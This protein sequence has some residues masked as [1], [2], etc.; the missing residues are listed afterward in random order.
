[1]T[2]VQ[3]HRDPAK[4]VR[5]SHAP[6]NFVPLSDRVYLPKASNG[7]AKG[8]SG[9]IEYKILV[10]TPLF[11]GKRP[12]D[13]D[14]FKRGDEY[15]IPGGAVRGMLRFV[16]RVISF[17]RFTPFED[18][19]LVFR[20][21]DPGTPE[22]RAYNELIKK[23]DIHAGFLRKQG[24]SF[25][26]QKAS[27]VK[28]H[29]FVKVAYA[30]VKHYF[31][32]RKPDEP[33]GPSDRMWVCLKPRVDRDWLVVDRVQ[34][35]IGIKG[36]SKCKG[37]SV[38]AMLFRTGDVRGKRFHYAFFEPD[39]KAEAIPVPGQY[40][41][42][43]L[44]D[45]Y[46]TRTLFT[47]H[48]M[49][50]QD[51]GHGMGEP[52]FY[53]MLDN[54]LYF[55]GPTRFSRMRSMHTIGAFVPGELRSPGQPDLVDTIFGKPGLRGKISVGD[56]L[57]QHDEASPFDGTVRVGA[58]CRPRPESS[59]HY[60]VQPEP[61]DTDTLKTWYDGPGATTLRG[62]K[63]YW[64][65]PGTSNNP[66]TSPA[67]HGT[68]R[69][70]KPVTV[71]SGF[72][73]VIRFD[74]LTE[75]QLGCLLTSIDLPITK[76]HRLGLGRPFGLGSVRMEARTRLFDKSAMYTQVTSESG[77]ETGIK[78]MPQDESEKVVRNA[79]EAFRNEMVRFYNEGVERDN[80]ISGRSSVWDIPGPR[81]LGVLLEWTNAPAREK[82]SYM[83]FDGDDAQR[84]T[85]R[86]VLPTA[87]GVA[88]RAMV[89]TTS[90][91]SI[92]EA[93]DEIEVW[94]GALLVY[95]PGPR[96]LRIT[97]GQKKTEMVADRD[98]LIL[99]N[100]SNEVR[101]RLIKKK[102]AIKVIAR[103]AHEGNKYSLLEIWPGI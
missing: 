17:G 97:H 62:A 44:E 26:I 60:L 9:E 88:S 51:A 38:R 87:E 103:V 53:Y 22:G 50:S 93:A 98:M 73:G 32:P 83:G 56:A 8:L 79:L 3:R 59:Q 84:W 29:E 24:D 58:L 72:A 34:D 35:C 42:A 16:A 37:G 4:R 18:R 64:H 66:D 78:V 36:R 11:V 5:V 92:V 46:K 75:L 2:V 82:T 71:G 96:L 80:R 68:F 23:L 85:R 76:A 49:D 95:E 61:D 27:T 99:S 28:G 41:D 67:R 91:E 6:Y 30:A 74:N 101:N 69:R 33:Y 25:F 20:G 52:V 90:T 43:Y 94:E 15:V 65:R 21:F 7:G 55:F 77:D 40:A 45:L 100:L 14:F 39:E 81:S 1:M 31:K 48:L 86:A 57:M 89:S 63:F 102:K 12:G 47:R 19:F 54:E 13:T 10:K 70:V